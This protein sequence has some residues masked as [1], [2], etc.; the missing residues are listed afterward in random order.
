MGERFAGEALFGGAEPNRAP[1]VSAAEIETTGVFTQIRAQVQS[2]AAGNG[3]TVLANTKQLAESNDPAVSPFRGFAAD[4]ASGTQQDARRSVPVGDGIDIP[5]GMLAY[6][7][8]SSVSRGNTTGSWSRDLIWGLSVIAN[9]EP[10]NDATRDDYKT[11][12]EG[13]V[14]ALRSASDALLEDQAGLGIEQSRLNKSTERNENLVFQL[15]M[16][17]SKIET[18]DLTDAITQLTSARTQLEA[19]YRVLVTLGD[20]SLTKFMR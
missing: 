17:I 20:L 12:V 5:I 6:G 16:Q 10:P 19:S 7:N 18:V 8:S 2:L 15:E 4:A 9:L 13:A 11:L 1:I 14:G 3:S